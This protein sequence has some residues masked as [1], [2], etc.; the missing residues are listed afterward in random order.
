MQSSVPRETLGQFDSC[1]LLD[2]LSVT[3]SIKANRIES[4]N[5]CLGWQSLLTNA[6]EILS[7]PSLPVRLFGGRVLSSEFYSIV[8]RI[9]ILHSE[10][11]TKNPNELIPTKERINNL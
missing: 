6:K 2:Y 1:R 4:G 7:P 3:G 10:Y 9:N 5:N 8:Q 11:I